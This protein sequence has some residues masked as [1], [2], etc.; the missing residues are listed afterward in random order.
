MIEPHKRKVD[1]RVVV[2]TPEGVDFQF[3]IA[4]PGTRAWAWLIDM[5]LKFGILAGVGIILTF[6]GLISSASENVVQGAMLIYGFLM[7]WF[8]GGL[9]EWWMNG[10]T[11]GKK[12][13]RT[14]RGPNKR[15]P[16]RYQKRYRT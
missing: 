3:V 8:Y 15:N 14:S 11:P 2:E 12:I 7:E 9:F 13:G 10:Q 16:S 4:G 6:F 1:T 5:L